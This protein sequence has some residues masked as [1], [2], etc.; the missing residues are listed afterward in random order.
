MILAG[1]ILADWIKIYAKNPNTEHDVIDRSTCCNIIRTIN[2]W[3][4]SNSETLIQ[5]CRV[6]ARLLFKE[7]KLKD[8]NKVRELE[9]LI[10]SAKNY[11]DRYNA[12]IRNASV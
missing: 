7:L 4:S 5:H 6:L 12:E 1:D 2:A 9:I 3:Y 11:C 8:L 10:K